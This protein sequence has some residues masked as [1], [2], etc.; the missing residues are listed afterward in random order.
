MTVR[1]RFM[2]IPLLLLGAV[3]VAAQDHDH[4]AGCGAKTRD[5][6]LAVKTARDAVVTSAHY[7]VLE[8]RLALTLDPAATDYTG[9]LFLKYARLADESGRVVLDCDGPE[10]TAVNDA[11][12]PL[13]FVQAGDSLVITAGTKR[14]GAVDS[15]TIAFTKPLVLRGE[16]LSLWYQINTPGEE[17]GPVISSFSQPE[18]ARTWWPCKDR[19][20]DKAPVTV[21]LTVP[22]GLTPVSN[23]VRIRWTANGDGTET[24]VWRERHPVPTY[25]VSVAVTDYVH[26]DETCVSSLSG[27]V[28]LDHYVFPMDQTKAETDFA[29]TCAMMNHLESLFGP[30]PFADEKY[31]HAAFLNLSSGAMEHTTLTSYGRGLLTGTNIYD[32]VVLHELAHQWFGDAITPVDWADIWLNEGFATYAECLWQEHLVGLDGE[33][34]YH[35]WLERLRPESDWIGA[36]TVY[37]SFPILSR[38]VYDKGAWILHMLRGRLGD[39]D[40]FD[41]LH[42]WASDPARLH[43]NATTADFTALAEQVSGQELDAFFDPWL[44][45]DTVPHIEM[46]TLVGDGPN[47]TDTRVT[48]RLRDR[49]GVEF[50]TVFPVWIETP[51]TTHVRAVRLVGS[52]AVAEFDLDSSVQRVTLDPEHWVAWRS[53]AAGDPP[54]RIT[55]VSPNPSLQGNTE[56]F[57]RLE[58]DARLTLRVYDARGHRLREIPVGLLTGSL[59]DQSLVWDGRDDAGRLVAAGV[60]WAEIEADGHRSHR[61]FTLLR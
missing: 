25:L 18:F 30:Y 12:G 16:G 4:D 15:L 48:V 17:A 52:E 8:Y 39:D 51:G 46:K 42:D 14:L 60:Y 36:T 24:T 9:T 22:V 2:L 23:G 13:P 61:K 31:G 21:S 45:E 1:F 5:A 37:D 33:R 10:V 47:G 38:V 56:L 54:V 49:S 57:F 32:W 11:G 34:G 28:P 3:S 53:V 29:P 41:L 7:D 59:E 55:R 43:G 27:T 6:F 26:L 35:W 58:Q 44:H 50:D 40:F 19:P 20:D